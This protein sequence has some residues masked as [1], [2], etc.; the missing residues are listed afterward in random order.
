MFSPQRLEFSAKTLFPANVQFRKG[1]NL[2]P[3]L[4]IWE[5]R[6]KSVV[7]I[8]NRRQVAALALFVFCCLGFIGSMWLIRTPNQDGDGTDNPEGD[9]FV[10]VSELVHNIILMIGDG[11]GVGQLNATRKSLG[12]PL[13]V[14]SFPIQDLIYTFSLSGLITDSAAAATALACG[15]QTWNG[16]VGMSSVGMAHRTILEFAELI[17]KSTGLV[18]TSRL[19]HATPA[20]FASHVQDRNQESLIGQQ[21][22]FEHEIEV[23]LG[24]GRTMLQPFFSGAVAAGYTIVENRSQLLD[25]SDDAKLLG[26]F[27]HSHMSYEAERNA[28]LEPS[29]AEMA[30]L[31]IQSLA[32]NPEGF[33]LMIEGGRID[34]ACHD[35]NITNTV[36]DGLAF[37]DAVD[38]ALQFAEEDGQTLLIVTADHETGGLWVNT[39]SPE[40]DVEWSTTGHTGDRVPFFIFSPDLSIIPEMDHH[41]DMGRFL[42]RAFGYVETADGKIIQSVYRELLTRQILGIFEQ[43]RLYS[44]IKIRVLDI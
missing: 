31:T 23:L 10:I 29:L 18:T 33:F 2:L 39:T 15:I 32:R 44:T 5:Q 28:S 40:L 9:G 42:F 24:G 21:M 25:S 19:T 16:V 43:D 37:N 22:L 27:K 6:L 7:D 26:L 1:Y 8:M 35:N 12:A 41:T 38:V 30:N 4:K 11:N 20:C 17:N 34:H 36:G 13:F 14:D 3:R